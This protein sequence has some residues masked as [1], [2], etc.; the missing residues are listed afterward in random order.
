MKECA[1]TDTQP[2][3]HLTA[4]YFRC[5]TTMWLTT[6]EEFELRCGYG[7]HHSSHKTS[8]TL[9]VK[10]STH[11]SSGKVRL[12]CGLIQW[13]ISCSPTIKQT[14][15]SSH[16]P[17]LLL[18][19]LGSLILWSRCV[20]QQHL[21]DRKESLVYLKRRCNIPSFPKSRHL[22][23]TGVGINVTWCEAQSWAWTVKQIEF[24]F[25]IRALHWTPLEFRAEFLEGGFQFESSDC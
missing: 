10:L 15:L 9:P 2:C 6:T 11:S 25:K 16:S 5:T 13:P 23:A 14:N 7:S 3:N 21:L 19:L 1:T 22:A 20:S 18:V 8:P 17:G 24:V 4:V 12:S